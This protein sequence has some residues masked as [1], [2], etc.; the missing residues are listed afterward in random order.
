[1]TVQSCLRYSASNSDCLCEY[2]LELLP[3]IF[4]PLPHCMPAIPMGL[5]VSASVKLRVQIQAGCVTL[6]RGLGSGLSCRERSHLPPSSPFPCPTTF[7]STS[8][9]PCYH[10]VLFPELACHKLTPPFPEQTLVLLGQY[11]SLRWPRLL[12]SSHKHVL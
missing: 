10:P 1:M 12:P 4:I 9:H 6:V 7:L 8:V 3:K 5:L 2:K 11:A